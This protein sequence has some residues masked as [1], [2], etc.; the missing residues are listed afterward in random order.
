M[1]QV[2]EQSACSK[3][4]SL[5]ARVDDGQVRITALQSELQSALDDLATQRAVNQQLMMKKEEVEWEL[6][7]A[8][9][10]VGGSSGYWR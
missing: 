10:E 8:L 5:E 2:S 1:A 7:A 3:L 6:M 4:A 9:A